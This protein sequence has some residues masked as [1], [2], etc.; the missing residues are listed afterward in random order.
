[1]QF[2][3]K[4]YPNSFQNRTE[5]VEV[6]TILI[7]LLAESELNEHLSSIGVI[8]DWLQVAVGLSEDD[9]QAQII[10]F[11]KDGST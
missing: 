7:E 5:Q 3:T 1:V 11:S 2:F 8:S 4:D 6:T 9:L 10:A